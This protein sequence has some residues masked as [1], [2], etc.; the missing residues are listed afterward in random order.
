MIPSFWL[1]PHDALHLC[2]DF[3]HTTGADSQQSRILQ[4]LLFSLAGV[5]EIDLSR[6]YLLDP[7]QRHWAASLVAGLGHLSEKDL[8]SG[9]VFANAA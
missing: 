2:H 9:L 6:L 8:T 1:D 7:E 3:I 4:E 5:D